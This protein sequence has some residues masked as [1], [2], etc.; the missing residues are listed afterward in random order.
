MTLKYDYVAAT[1]KGQAA[2]ALKVT[3]T[4]AGISGSGVSYLDPATGMY[5]GADAPAAGSTT[6]TSY[7]PPDYMDRI[8]NAVYNIGQVANVAVKTRITGKAI[9]DAFVTIGGGTA[10]TMDYTFSVE[11]KPNETLVVPAGSFA[12]S[13]KLIINVAVS[14]VR[15][16]GND[17][18]NPLFAATFDTLASAFTQP[19]KTTVWLTNKMV[20]VPR[21]LVETS[22][23][24]TGAISSDQALTTYTLAPR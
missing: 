8:T 7:D 21:G 17:G 5:L 3:T 12:N 1:Y 6:V 4:V 18:S 15:L 16:E 19:F 13:C 10:L 23:P 20:N 9:T 22:G 24:L 14:N 2:L 11:R